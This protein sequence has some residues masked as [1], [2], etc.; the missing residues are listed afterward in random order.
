MNPRPFGTRTRAARLHRTWVKALRA[1]HEHLAIV[2]PDGMLDGVCERSV[3]YVAKRKALGHRHHCEM[4]H[5]RYRNRS[6]R[7]RGK[8]FLMSSALL[9]HNRQRK[10]ASYRSSLDPLRKTSGRGAAA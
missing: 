4:C 5:P 3:W 1:R 8:P 2:H 6:T 10:T 7:T 9:P